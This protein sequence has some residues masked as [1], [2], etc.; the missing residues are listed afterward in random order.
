MEFFDYLYEPQGWDSF[1]FFSLCQIVIK[2][3]WQENQE[4]KH[5]EQQ[6]QQNEKSRVGRAQMH[7]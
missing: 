4:Q 3:Q 6:Q 7:S 1:L 5:T 2:P